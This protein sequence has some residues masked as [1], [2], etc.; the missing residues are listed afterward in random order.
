MTGRNW[1]S[2]NISGNSG[3][4]TLGDIGAGAVVGV[5]GNA[6]LPGAAPELLAAVGKQLEGLV[7][8]VAQL[9]HAQGL[10]Q[11]KID[12][13]AA[14]LEHLQQSLGGPEPNEHAFQSA[15]SSLW[16]K[17]KMVADGVNSV[18]A[19]AENLVRIA[20]LLGWTLAL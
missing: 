10:D 18:T 2:I 8:A 17:I 1:S 14:D 20:K 9:A 11:R 7:A 19:L 13:L 4:V 15:A 12:L 3:P 16:N 6:I 5:G